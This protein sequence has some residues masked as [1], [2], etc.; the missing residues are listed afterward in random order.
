LGERV[1]AFFRVR[2]ID[3]AEA[4]VYRFAAAGSSMRWI[5]GMSGDGAYSRLIFVAVVLLQYLSLV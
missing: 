3:E 2:E 1:G 5:M 4:S